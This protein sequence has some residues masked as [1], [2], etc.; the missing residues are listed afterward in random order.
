[1]ATGDKTD[2]YG[3]LMAMLP[4]WFGDLTIA[5]LISALLQAFATTHSYVYTLI[6]YATLQVRIKTATDGWLDMIAADFFGPTFYRRAGQSDTSFRAAIVLNLFRERGTRNSVIKILTDLT[7]RAPLIVEF[8]RPTDT[9]VWGG[10]YLGYG[11]AGAYGS[12]SMDTYAMVTAY[13]PFN[14]GTAPFGYI[15]TDAEIYAAVDSVRPAG[16]TLLMNIKN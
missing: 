1:M 2:V 10:P 12:F 4:R 15:P 6:A 9:G 7:G 8:N 5:P 14:I 16:Y 3:R 13:R 11:L